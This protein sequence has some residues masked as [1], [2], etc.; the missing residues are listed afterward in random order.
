MRN[1]RLKRKST[2]VSKVDQ[3]KELYKK[4]M[5]EMRYREERMGDE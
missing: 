3:E 2:I 5:E 4:K 1:T